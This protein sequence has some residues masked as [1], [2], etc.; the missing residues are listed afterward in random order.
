MGRLSKTEAIARGLLRH[1]LPDATFAFSIRPTTKLGAKEYQITQARKYG[2]DLEGLE[3]DI[4]IEEFRTII[5]VDGIQHGR[6]TP[7]FHRKPHDFESQ[8]ERDRRK[9]E[10]CKAQGVELHKLDIFDLTQRRFEPFIREL[11]KRHGRFEHY[12]RT[13][14]PRVLFVQAERLSRARTPLA[15]AQTLNRPNVWTAFREWVRS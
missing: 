13:T 2:F 8:L 15:P 12:R 11:C 5:E 3:G 4:L 1:Y 7:H 6:L 9:I 14:P 10:L